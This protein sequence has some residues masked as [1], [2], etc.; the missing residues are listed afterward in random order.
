MR[1]SS[2]LLAVLVAAGCA[3]PSASRAQSPAAAAPAAPEVLALV[4]GAPIT[5]ADL[6][7]V[8]GLELARLEEQLYQMRKDQL[9]GLIALR[10]FEAEARRRGVTPQQFEETEVAAKAGVVTEPEI[11][12]FIEANRARIRGDVVQLRPQIRQFLQDQKRQQRRAAVVEGLRTAATVDVRLA[13]PAPFRAEVDI[14][15]APVRGDVAAPVTIIEYSDF[16]CP[17]CRRVQPTL[18]ALLEKYKGKVRL[19]YKHLPLDQLHPN[20]RRVSEA[21]YCAARQEKFWAFHDAVYAD[22]SSDASEATLARYATAA[23]LDAAA[24]NACLA[25]PEAREAVARDLAQGEALGLSST[26]GFFVNGREVRGAQPIE[27]FT[28]I[29]DE[30]LSGARR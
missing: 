29:I 10:L 19:V 3:G 27:A 5:E 2:L 30:E 18:T 28:A 11:D 15:G 1:V 4:N 20:A 14:A 25:G 12:A 13:P 26:P 16:H 7:K 21:S 9:D 24:F 17:F 23:G 6:R 22:A 8:A